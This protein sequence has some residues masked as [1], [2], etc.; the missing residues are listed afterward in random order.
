MKAESS[1][2]QQQPA[3]T[4]SSKVFPA[5]AELAPAGDAFLAMIAAAARDPQVDIAKM[6]QLLEMRER[7]MAQQAEMAYTEA[8]NRVQNAV[9]PIYK[10]RKIIVKGQLRSKYAALEDIDKLLRPLIIQ[11]GFS[12]SSSTE[13]V[14]PKSTKLILTV[15]HR[16]GHKESFSLVLPID[17]SEYRSESQNVASTVSFGRRTLL[18]LAFNV[19]TLDIDTDGNPPSEFISQEQALTI[20]TLL[21]DCRINP[22]DEKFLAWCGADAVEHIHAGEYQR[23]VELLEKRKQQPKS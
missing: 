6:Q 20:F 22:K 1:L 16:M 23:I 7:L 19:I 5:P 10:T 8:M 17:K 21:R 3:A 14:P 18:C 4:D 9:P 2:I 11:E 15:K 12:L 13:D